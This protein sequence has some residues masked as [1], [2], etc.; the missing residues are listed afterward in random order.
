MFGVTLIPGSSLSNH[1]GSWRTE[2]PRFST[3]TPPCAASCHAGEPVREWILALQNADRDAIHQAWQVITTTNP[4]PAT[5][6]RICYA[7]CEQECNRKDFGGALRI[8]DLEGSIGEY[9][10]AQGW[11]FPQ[12][13]TSVPGRVAVVGSGPCGLAAAYH[14]RRAGLEVVLYESRRSLGGMLHYSISENRLP[15]G[16]LGA[17]IERIL[18]MGVAH[19]TKV[20]ILKVQDILPTYDGVI[21]AT[22]ASTCMAIVAGQTVWSQPI[23]RGGRTRRTCTVS[24]GRGT[25]AARALSD[26]LQGATSPASPVSQTSPASPTPAISPTSAGPLEPVVAR[27]D[28][29]NP[30]YYDPHPANILVDRAPAQ[31]DAG[32]SGTGPQVIAEASRCMCCGS[33]FLCDN[34][35]AVCPDNAIEKST[36]GYTVREDYCKGCGI[37][38]QECPSGAISMIPL[39]R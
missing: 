12:P 19:H 2:T 21:W 35:Y 27:S 24:I 3:L 25:A 1:T 4:L 13:T 5:M 20:T 30:W 16:I 28:V 33:C 39:H 36:T 17:E 7:S 29:L 8:R 22:G 6:G 18:N 34:C 31:L 23:H 32:P 10:L 14:L 9:A 37:C 26:F 15:K 11:R 38:A